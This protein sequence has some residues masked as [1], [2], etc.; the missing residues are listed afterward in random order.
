MHTQSGAARPSYVLAER[1]TSGPQRDRIRLSV[2]AEIGMLFASD[3][4]HRAV[5]NRVAHAMVP[6]L[7]DRC[8]IY[9]RGKGDV[10]D[11]VAIARTDGSCPASSHL[12][13][14]ML[15]RNR[16]LGVMQLCRTHDPAYDRDDLAFA[17]ELARRL[18]MY[19]DHALLIRD[20]AQLIRDLEQSNRDLDQFVDVASHD[21]KAPMRGIANLAQMLEQDLDDRTT[22]TDRERFGLLRARVRR[23]ENMIDG[24]LRYSRA[25]R[26]VDERPMVVDVGGLAR[27]VFELL[28]PPAGAALELARDLPRIHTVRQPLE[29]VFLNLIGNALKHADRPDPRIAIAALRTSCGWEIAVRDNGPGIPPELHDQ[30]WG[31]FRALRRRG[32]TNSDDTSALV[33]SNC[34]G[35]G[36][37]I[38]RRIVE[39]FGG[40]VALASQ[41]GAGATFKFTWKALP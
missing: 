29:Q 28:A 25:G 31:M 33:E 40:R 7:C 23:L 37:A 3:D 19:V 9:L 11:R 30:I 14:P 16:V 22:E 6:T 10:L 39:S 12:A 8:A 35:I 18:A 27:E 24:V 26:V 1:R 36:L 38:V 13:M 5:L 34:T 41:P 32:S 17:E 21:L 20:Q 4:D 15:V 2:L